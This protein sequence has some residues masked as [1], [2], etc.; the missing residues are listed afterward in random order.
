MN[1]LIDKKSLILRWERQT[2]NIWLRGRGY[3]HPE[4]VRVLIVLDKLC[5][6]KELNIITS[7]HFCLSLGML[8]LWTQPPCHKEATASD[9][10]APML[11]NQ[12]LHPT[13]PAKLPANSQHQLASRQMHY[14]KNGSFSFIFPLPVDAINRRNKVSPSHAQTMDSRVKVMLF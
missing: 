9:R 10:E 6:M 1:K 14:L 13:V 5:I 8:P 4:C 2:A 3:K 12:A 7:S 11:K